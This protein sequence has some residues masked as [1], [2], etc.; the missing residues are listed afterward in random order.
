MK[1]EELR[2]L[3]L[4]EDQVNKIMRI[5]GQDIE[6]YKSQVFNLSDQLENS[7]EK[8]ST[9]SDSVDYKTKFEDMENKYNN[10]QSEFNNTKR[11]TYI[12]NKL[13]NKYHNNSMV[14]GQILKANPNLKLN[15]NGEINELGEILKDYDKENAYMIKSEEVNLP[16]FLGGVSNKH[17]VG[18][19]ESNTMT[20]TIIREALLNDK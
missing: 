18:S 9:N 8:I 11:D 5:Y 1:R 13:G 16:T 10:L 3:G 2:T 14:L 17:T 7:K 15:E 19:I 4:N 12:L 20:N 6:N